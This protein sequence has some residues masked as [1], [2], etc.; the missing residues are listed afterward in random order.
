MTA[1]RPHR[2]GG[3]ED[4]L[5]EVVHEIRSRMGGQP[6]AVVYDALVRRLSERAPGYVPDE[7]YL[8]VAAE[9]VS[10]QDFG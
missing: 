8:K 1:T 9:V 6:E 5:H 2:A 3:G 4:I 10:E 7:Q